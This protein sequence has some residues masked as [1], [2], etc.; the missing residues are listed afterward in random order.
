MNDL[1]QLDEAELIA[2]FLAAETFGV[3]GVS[4]DPSKYGHKVLA[5]YLARGRRAIPIHPRETEILGQRVYASLSDVTEAIDAVSIIT[6][7]QVTE[8]VVEEI[9]ANGIPLV[10]MQP[11]AESASAVAKARDLGLG[12]IHGGPCVMVVLR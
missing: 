9:A 6:P 12:V 4:R 2:R 5:H 3:V 10:W 7:P 8:T 11:G 1:T